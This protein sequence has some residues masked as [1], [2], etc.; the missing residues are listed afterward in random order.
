MDNAL[1]ADRLH[2]RAS[3][4]ISSMALTSAAQ[5]RSIV[6][7][8]GMHRSGTSL[9]SHILSM[10]G[11]DMADV[12]GVDRGN[13]RGHW[14]RWEIVEFH[15]RILALFNRGYFGPFHDFPLPV[16]W[17]ADPRVVQIRR[18]IVAFVEK[19]MSRTPF[20]F[21]DPRTVRLMPLWHQI[22][23]ELKLAP[24]IVL[25]LRNPAQVARSLQARDGLAPG[26]GEHRWLVYMMDFFRFAGAHEFCVLEYERWFDE[27]RANLKKLTSLLGLEWQHS[28]ADL[29][30]VL[31]EIIDPA[32]RHDDAD[33]RGAGQPLVRSFYG[34]AARAADDAEA[35]AQIDDVASQLA[36][37]EQLYKPFRQSFEDALAA[38]AKLPGIEQAAAALEQ[39]VG[40]REAAAAAANERAGATE[41]RLAD[42]ARELDAQRA[43][44]AELE[45]ERDQSR[46]AS[47]HAA[48][49]AIALEAAVS[50]REAATAAAD[51]RANAAEAR[52]AATQSELAAADQRVGGA[53]ARLSDTLSELEVQKVR[54]AEFER[55]RAEN[56]VALERAAQEQ[57][58]ERQA[59]RAEISIL[60]D[61]VGATREAGRA[62]IDALRGMVERAD[63][64]AQEGRAKAAEMADDNAAM[65]LAVARAEQI[66]H[67]R[68]A[69]AEAMRGE[70][71]TLC[72]KLE[73]AEQIARDHDIA[74]EA[75][76]AEIATLRGKLE[77]ADQ[78]AQER[79]ATAAA[80]RQAVAQ[81]EQTAHDRDMAA[82]AMRA[83]IVSLRHDV[84][85]ARQVGRAMIAALRVDPNPPLL[86]RIARKRW[87]RRGLRSVGFTPIGRSAYRAAAA[88]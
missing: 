81:A 83:E 61:K 82:E 56:A 13:D 44:L 31:A 25:C 27:P 48:Q 73:R 53:E 20:G 52:L 1:A 5:R 51:Q 87:W 47:E 9:C 54:F 37:Y 2:E 34:L 16:A 14:E 80:L 55:Q 32:L 50:E 72:G 66:A 42:T 85:A 30:L 11:V 59:L 38:A 86:N 60:Q 15:D 24:K 75:M 10:L 4:Q 19:R 40:E 68:N 76:R 39:A 7:V 67:D 22:F 23:I 57:A 77:R 62:A 46:A 8:L 70:I 21:K 6:M 74:T 29:E 88:G 41:G 36:G 28:E 71:A 84:A 26:I 69:V 35:R 43:Q 64:V 65:R 58:A 3:A 33:R 12:I 17:W 49:A 63:R 45:L 78:A 18:E 79:G